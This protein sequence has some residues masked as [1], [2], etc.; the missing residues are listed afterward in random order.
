MKK[1]D[2]MIED[3]AKIVA[4]TPDIHQAAHILKLKAS[5]YS[6]KDVSV[7]IYALNQKL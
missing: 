7:I 2:S 6:L 4:S 3:I 1:G 5:I